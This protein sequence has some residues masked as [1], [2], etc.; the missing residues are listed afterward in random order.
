LEKFG[1]LN[2]RQLT[3]LDLKTQAGMKEYVTR[4]H[5]FECTERLKF[6]VSSALEIL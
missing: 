5:D 3:G 1:H 6:A 4:V 2:C